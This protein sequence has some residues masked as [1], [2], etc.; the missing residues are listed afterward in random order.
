[1]LSIWSGPK[2]CH[3]GNGLKETK[4]MY[5]FHFVQTTFYCCLYGRPLSTVVFMADNFLLLSLWQTTFESVPESK[6][7]S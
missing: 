1:M 6:K 4:L 3:S 7:F 2:F 5:K